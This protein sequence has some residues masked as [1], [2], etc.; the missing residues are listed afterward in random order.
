MTV[1]M[2]SIHWDALRSFNISAINEAIAICHVKGMNSI[3]ALNY[4]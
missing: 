3:M 1:D 4:D 2:K